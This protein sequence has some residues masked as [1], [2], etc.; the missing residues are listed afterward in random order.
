MSRPL[1]AA[2]RA[3]FVLALL[4]RP[5]L[6]SAALPEGETDETI[7]YGFPEPRYDYVCQDGQK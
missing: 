1:E 5:R 4:R 7:V 2:L 3:S 6:A